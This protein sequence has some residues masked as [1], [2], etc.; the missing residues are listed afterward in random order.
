MTV[1]TPALGEL[2]EAVGNSPLL[3][4]ILYIHAYSPRAFAAQNLELENI[5]MVHI[6]SRAIVFTRK[7]KW[8]YGLRNSYSNFLYSPTTT[9]A[10]GFPGYNRRSAERR[11]RDKCCVFLHDCTVWG[12]WANRI[13]EQR[14]ARDDFTDATKVWRGLNEVNGWPDRHHNHQ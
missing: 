12:Q 4:P 11:K 1:C 9:N 10:D 13:L 8:D 6:L 7:L 2:S 14:S 3:S 5:G